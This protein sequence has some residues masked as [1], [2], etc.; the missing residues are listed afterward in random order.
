[1]TAE[2]EPCIRAGF[3]HDS[4]SSGGRQR[5][6]ECARKCIV[7]IFIHAI[8][9]LAILAAFVIGHWIS[10]ERN[11]TN[12]TA[13]EIVASAKLANAD[14]ITPTPMDDDRARPT[15][16]TT[17]SKKAQHYP[18]V[19][20]RIIPLH[21]KRNYTFADVF[22]PPDNGFD[23][24]EQLH[25]VRG[26]KLT[27]DAL[28]VPLPLYILPYHYDLKLDLTRF[29]TA[30]FV[31][32]NI[33]IHLESYGN[34]TEDEI[35]FHIGPNI[36]IERMRLRMGTRKFYA[37]TF[38]RE[39]SKKLGRIS[40]RD[41]LQKGKYILEIEYNMTIC[42]EDV[43]GVRCSLD[44]TTNSS[45]KSTSFTTK[46]E[47]TLARS[48]I[49][50]W[51]EPGVKATFNISVKHDKKYT[52]LANMPPIEAPPHLKWNTNIVTTRFQQTPPMSTYLLA[53]AI[54]EFVKLETRTE[55][56][57]PVTVWTYPE[58][59]MSMKFTLD[60]APIIFDR[61]EE[62]LEISYP[63]PKI[64]MIAAR[65]F[66]VGGMENWGLI[67]F[68]F[69]SVAYTPS[70]SDHVNETVDRMYNEFR[71][72]KLIAHE[73]A[74]QWFGNLVTMR[75]WSEV[76]LNEG[77][78][79]FYVYEMM[80]TERPITS[81]FE[82]FDNLNALFAAQSGEDH[83][84]AL[85]R[86]LAT[87]S[88]VELSFHP[89]NL[90]TKGCVLIRMIRDLV[91]DFDFKAAVRR[92]LRKNA[93]RSVSRDDLF[94][95][96]PGYADHGADQ[97]KLN[98]VLEGWFVNEGIPEVT[99]TRNYDNEMMTMSQRKTIRH[100]Y[101]AFLKDRKLAAIFRVSRTAESND[102]ESVREARDAENLDGSTPFDDTLFDG[103]PRGPFKPV[104]SSISR[105][106][107]LRKPRRVRNP[108]DLWT[109]PITYMFGSLKTSEG[110]VIR[111]FW[112]KNRT[113]SFG[114]GEISPTQA[115]LLNPDWKYP[116]RVNYDLL[117]WKLLARQLHQS[118]QEIPDKSRMQL[119][120]DAEYF[121]G[122]SNNPHLYLYLLGYLAHETKLEVMLFGID[123][124]Y[125]FIDMFKATE[126]NQAILIYF[127]PVVSQMDRLL[128]ESQIDAE[129]ASLW[130]VRPERLSKLYQLR[131]ATSLPSCKN[132]YHTQK[133]IHAPDEWTEDVNK[134][135]TA[136]CHQLFATTKQ[137][138]LQ[139]VHDILDDRLKS[140]GP[141]WVL[142]VQLAACSHDYR[143]LKKTAKAIVNTKNAAVYASAL[144]SDFSL[145]YNAAFRK[146]FWAEIA[147]MSTLEKT[148]LFSTNSTT[149][150]PASRI[151]LHSIRTIDE[152]QQVRGLLTNWG[153]LMTLHFE[154]LERYLLWISTISQGVLHQFFSA[155]LSSL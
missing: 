121:L 57:V 20:E 96:L 32:A 50:C 1:M 122:N 24:A 5:K 19:I 131:C 133:W 128:A 9:I 103:T 82:Y 139:S 118:H 145:H 87:E 75:D 39:E 64:D 74:H 43:D 79:T 54:G 123:A 37:K 33:S 73:A 93:Y 148:A 2:V 23:I 141:K 125:N 101:R 86:D 72:G 138:D 104:I 22:P 13:T 116:Y 47:P 52:V 111:E 58:D 26:N 21:K 115:V 76:F 99:L 16:L 27:T 17:T 95:S 40:L 63:L 126:L 84:L 77:F 153:A 28:L 61:L 94:S 144:Q 154:Y 117:N 69:S 113:V 91:T 90:Y 62:S 110:Q 34:S 83:R 31:R 98:D 119:I 108:A 14:R 55:R 155:D 29:D 124:V 38:K 45:L 8:F 105:R 127:A 35:Q 140:N 129:T 151:L 59:V 137:E 18:R 143:L 114:D 150:L 30:Q 53:F 11:A 12:R 41:P 60:Y 146:Y 46:F 51:D 142:M 92:Y 120:V 66:H 89:T 147:R 132:A 80:S 85:V 78:A 25:A 107:E 10:E 102:T 106:D 100:E 134:Q 3:K 70:I 7:L 65:N 112:L 44:E 97:E 88:Q 49:P 149:I 81:E 109:I 152:L 67:V 130:L 56:G 36:N 135:V 136:V 42:D 48:F 4:T 71:I 6:S 68:E 15:L